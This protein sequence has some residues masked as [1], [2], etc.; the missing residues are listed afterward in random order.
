MLAGRGTQK[1]PHLAAFA[2]LMPCPVL[3]NA[4][5]GIPKVLID[6][7]K[8]RH[9]D[10]GA[11]VSRR[12]P[13]QSLARIRIPH[14]QRRAPYKVAYIDRIADHAA[15]EATADEGLMVPN[16]AVRRR[17]AIAIETGSNSARR[18]PGSIFTENAPHDRGLF[19]LDLAQPL[20][21]IT[22]RVELVAHPAIAIGDGAGNAAGAHQ[23][24]V[25]AAHVAGEVV[26]KE[27]PVVLR[28]P[29]WIFVTTPSL[30]VRNSTP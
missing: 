14:A 18:D 27:R 29:T 3:A 13:F 1:A 25:A 15:A 20:D 28:M 10:G 24:V 19:V 26:E 17:Y 2:K 7:A 5:R 4:I 6:D 23:A 8:V 30:G 16:A 21:D 22:A 12:H 9:L 11:V